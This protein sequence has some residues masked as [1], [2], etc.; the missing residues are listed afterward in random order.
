MGTNFYLKKLPSKKRK[1]ELIDAIKNDDEEKTN[2]LY[3]ELYV[4][5]IIHLGK[6]SYGW[7]FLFN[8]NFKS[9]FDDNTL[10]YKLEYIYPLTKK[11]IDKFIR[12][13]GCI[14]I[15][16]YNNIVSSE[17]FWELV[18]SKKDGIIEDKEEI[19]YWADGERQDNYY[20][21]HNDYPKGNYSYAYSFINDGLRFSYS[22]EFS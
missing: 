3:N 21:L 22:T 20:H 12:Q 9:V 5:N 13:K 8:P 18:D 17:K 2:L 15:D 6:S 1:K 14:I 11:G 4:D 7:Q 16:E 19:T 10:D